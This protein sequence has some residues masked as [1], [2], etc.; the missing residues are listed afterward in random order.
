MD[1]NRCTWLE[2]CEEVRVAGKLCR[3]HY[4]RQYYLSIRR[5]TP[6]CPS[7][8][9]E[10]KI[11]ADLC[12]DCR[13]TVRQATY[14]ASKN[15]RCQSFPC[16]NLIDVRRHGR[17][18]CSTACSRQARPWREADNPRRCSVDDCGKPHRAHGFCNSC[19]KTVGPG[20]RTAEERRSEYRW[21]D[22]R[23]NSYHRRRALRKGTSTGE[24]VDLAEIA[25]RDGW[26]CQICFDPV[27][28]DLIYPKWGSASQDHI[29]PLT[30]GGIHDPSN[31]QLAHLRCNLDKR[32]SMPVVIE[33]AD[34][35]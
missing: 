3:S 33:V 23:R 17:K 30:K 28:S 18:Y 22:A 19:L 6:Y 10:L 25:E 31:V 34:A 27:N 20:K 29:I 1:S 24:R 7:C 26:I 9:R 4:N 16:C 5:A 21:T 14:L 2:G 15:S 32:D 8:G 12:P 13:E 11:R 35:G